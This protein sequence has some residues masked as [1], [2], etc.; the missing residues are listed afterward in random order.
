M[1]WRRGQGKART[2]T[3]SVAC[4][5]GEPRAERKPALTIV[6]A[7]VRRLSRRT[8]R[9]VGGGG[10]RGRPRWPPVAESRGAPRALKARHH[11]RRVAA[12]PDD[13]SF[14]RGRKVG[15]GAASRRRGGNGPCLATTRVA[16][17]PVCARNPLHPWI[18]LI[19]APRALGGGVLV[20]ARPGPRTAAVN[21]S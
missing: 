11:G 16:S 17:A 14:D 13:A 9:R 19:H 20:L 18:I 7:V 15:F 1:N 6:R 3:V 21:G 8:R 5:D 10:A 12:A 4:A 2:R